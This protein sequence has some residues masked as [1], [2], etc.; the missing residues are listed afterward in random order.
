MYSFERDSF[1]ANANEQY[2]RARFVRYDL[3][4]NRDELIRD[5][6]L[7]TNKHGKHWDYVPPYQRRVS[8]DILRRYF[9]TWQPFFDFQDYQMYGDRDLL[10]DA[11]KDAH[12][13]EDGEAD[14]GSGD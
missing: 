12:Y 14:E 1:R 7:S 8:G 3:L 4:K 11:L 2:T 6:L 5:G 9:L 13:F 10:P